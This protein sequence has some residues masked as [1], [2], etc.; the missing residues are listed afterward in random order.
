MHSPRV[1]AALESAAD[2]LVVDLGYGALPVTTL[3]LAARLRAVRA[4]IRVVGLEIDPARVVPAAST[5]C[6][7]ALGG[8]E[9]AG[10]QTG[11]GA[12][13]QRAAAVPGRGGARR[14]G[15]NAGARWR[16]AG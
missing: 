2:P 4:D 13:V 12:R 14:V 6:E 11:F 8:F 15:G 5:A 3:E 16:R 1:R 9:L 7:F 10:L